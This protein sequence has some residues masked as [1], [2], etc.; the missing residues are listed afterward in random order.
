MSNTEALILVGMLFVLP[1][2][3]YFILILVALLKGYK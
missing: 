2:V 1:M 3:L